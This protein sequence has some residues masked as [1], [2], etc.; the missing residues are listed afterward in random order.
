MHRIGGIG[1]HQL[2]IKD[3]LPPQ[4]VPQ[5]PVGKL[6]PQLGLFL[7]VQRAIAE[8]IDRQMDAFIGGDNIH[9]RGE[10]GADQARFQRHVLVEG[11]FHGHR[12]HGVEVVEK[13]LGNGDNGGRAPGHQRCVGG[14]SAVN[15]LRKQ[16]HLLHLSHEGGG[17]QRL[18]LVPDRNGEGLHIGP[19]A[20]IAAAQGQGTQQ[21]QRQRHRHHAGPAKKQPQVLGQQ[22]TK[23][24]HNRCSSTTIPWSRVTMRL[25]TRSNSE[26]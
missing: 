9:D 10:H 11:Q 2:R 13:I 4:C 24:L 5:Q 26:R 19:P 12:L 1:G 7:L 18:V 21:H 23:P 20:Q 17:H 8:I 15:D 22:G 16:F 25:Q 6:L 14:A 3:Q